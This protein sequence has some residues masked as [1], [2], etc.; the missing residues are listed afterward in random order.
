MNTFSFRAECPHDVEEFQREW[1][2][3]RIKTS[4]TMKRPDL[5]LPDVE[6]EIETESDLATLRGSMQ[7]VEDGHVMVQTLR[8]CPLKD[9]SLERNYD[10]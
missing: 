10:A 4:M 1:G 7:T 8:E 3:K 5:S 2:Q 9:N 6:V